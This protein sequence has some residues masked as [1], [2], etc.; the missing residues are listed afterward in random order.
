MNRLD[1]LRALVDYL[2]EERDTADRWAEFAEA[3]GLSEQELWTVFRAL[4][5]T[6][7]ALPAAPAFLTLQDDLLKDM[8]AEKGIAPLSATRT[9]PLHPRMRLWRGD[10][11]TLEVDAIVNAANSQMLGCWQPGH[12][13]IDNAIHTFAGVQL[14]LEC[15]R[16]MRE[17]GHDEPTGAAKVTPAFNLPARFIVHTVGPIANGRPT[18]AHRRE[19][20]SSYTSCLAAA[21]ERNLTSI[22]FCCIST[23]V[24]G[25]PGDEAASIAV[26]S[27][28]DW[29]TEHADSDLDVVFNV[30]TAE[31]E[32]RYRRLLGL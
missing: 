21:H 11:C 12:L 24:F 28:L 23:G 19:L 14:R 30:F 16:I 3:E 31:D 15:A 6:R 27:V 17:Q 10:I 32:T 18:D 29:L 7:E 13:C 2:V 4:V 5:N 20:R 8:I 25:F 1:A 9:V 26:T 22:A